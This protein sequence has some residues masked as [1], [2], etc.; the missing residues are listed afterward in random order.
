MDRRRLDH[1]LVWRCVVTTKHKLLLR[2]MTVLSGATWPVFAQPA[3]AQAAGAEESS[4]EIVVTAQKRAQNSQDIGIAVTAIGQSGLAQLGRQS[5]T[6]LSVQVPGLQVN[7]YSPTLTVFNIRGVSQND[8]AD[9]QEAP[10][11]FYNDEVY[12]SALGAISGQTFDLQRVEV[13]RGPQGT[14]FGRNATGGLVQVIT[15]KPTDRLDGFL[16]LT[17]G[18]YG[19]FA[20]EGAISGPLS[21]TVRGRFSFTTNNHRGYITNDLGPDRGGEKFYAARAQIAADLGGGTLTLKGEAMFNDHETSGGAYTLLVSAPNAQ[22]LGRALGPN[23]DYYGTCPGCTIFGFK[24]SADPFKTSSQTPTYFTRKYYNAMATY[25]KDLGWANLTSI[26]DYQRL[27]KDYRED[28]GIQPGAVFTYTTRQKLYQLSQELR[29]NG[30][31]DRLNWTLGAYG[32]KLN[33]QNNYVA[34]LDQSIGLLG[35]YGG[36]LNTESLA[37]FGQ[38]EYNLLDTFSVIGGLRYSKDWKTYDYFNDTTGSSRFV[39]NRQTYPKLARQ[40]FGNYSGKIELDYKPSRDALIYVS[41]NR[42]TKSGGFGTPA[43]QPIDPTTIPF[44]QEVLTNF[45]GG[46]KLTLFDRTTHF[47]ASAFYYKYKNYQAFTEVGLSQVIV[48]NKARLYG[49]EVTADTRPVD[50]LTLSAFLTLLHTKVYDIVLPFGDVADRVMPQAPKVSAGGSIEYAF[51]IGS[52]KATIHTDWKYDSVQYF[53]TFNAPVDREPERVI[54]SVRISYALEGGHWE[55]A[56]FANNVTNKAYRVYNLDLST[57]LGLSQQTYARPR[58][59]GA[60]LTYKIN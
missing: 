7:Q 3:L 37:A 38:V 60:S 42:G 21:D 27:L 6:A 49:L 19:Q 47:N 39:F 20:S 45:E 26:S 30:K 57:S 33:T 29:L 9:S 24:P 10:I 34:D 41:V 48:N 1:D 12:V 53:S 5:I 40:T 18:S 58:W 4:D 36:T 43:F 17:G 51:P 15:A 56:A 11:A 54:G 46:F 22:G 28:S 32:F 44:D 55:V 59:I 31:T 25:T 50:G 23:E 14:L 52:G 13:L 16:T 8:F 2:C 35:V